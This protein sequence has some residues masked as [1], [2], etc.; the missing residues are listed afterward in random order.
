MNWL[1]IEIF[2]GIYIICKIERE[3]LNNR[4]KD[5]KLK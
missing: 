5:R 2:F 1:K 3:K 4:I